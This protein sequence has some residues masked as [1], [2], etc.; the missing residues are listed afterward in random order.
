LRR[1]RAPGFG[2]GPPGDLVIET[3]VKPHPFFRREGLDLHLRLPVTISEALSG[4]AV[5][6]PTP[7]GNVRLKIPARSQSGA[8]LR[9]KERG[10][11]RGKERGDLYVELDVR[12]PDQDD[13][14]LAEA[15]RAADASYSRPVREGIKL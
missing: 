5:D 12:L 6:V 2:G 14:R 7:N 3:H 13:A 10:V 8:R 4:A 11:P 9:L 15:A 1:R